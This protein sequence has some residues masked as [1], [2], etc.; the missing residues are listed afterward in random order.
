M[1]WSDLQNVLHRYCLSLTGSSWEADDLTQDTWV[2]TMGK[3]KRLGHANPEAFL[4]RVAKNTWIDQLRRK[5]VLE[6]ILSAEKPTAFSSEETILEIE[7]IFRALNKH[8]TSLQ[9]TIFMLREVFGYSNA[10]SAFMLGTTEGAVK[11]ALHR[12]R[13]TLKSVREEIEEGELPVGADAD[14]EETVKLTA[15]AYLDGDVTKL[16]ELMQG[17]V[18][19]PA[20]VGIVLE[21]GA[22]KATFVKGNQDHSALRMAA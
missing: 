4:L 20:A 9:R 18:E 13:Q 15:L 14:Q 17:Q 10:E 8:M 11:T 22:R 7:M 6:R 12:A 21:S 5:T 1:I 16:I 2:K 3:L 19:L